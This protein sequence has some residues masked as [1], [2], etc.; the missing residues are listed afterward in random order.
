M[1]NEYKIL[2]NGTTEIY[3]KKID[4]RII[5]VKIDTADLKLVSTYDTWFAIPDKVSNKYYIRTGRTRN[6]KTETILLHRLIMD[7]P[8]GL[9][10]NHI[11]SNSTDNTRKNLEVVTNQKNVLHG[12]QAIEVIVRQVPS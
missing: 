4:G 10:V 3:C 2:D 12:K 5:T 11:N 9:V 8:E 7:F 6:H 1:K